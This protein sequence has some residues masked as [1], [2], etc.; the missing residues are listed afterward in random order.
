MILNEFVGA[1]PTNSN[2]ILAPGRHSLTFGGLAAQIEATVRFLNAHGLGRNDRV[3][4]VLPNGPELAVAF[5]CG[6]G[7]EQPSLL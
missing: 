7:P 6:L 3:A 2:V 5:S 1:R 4:A